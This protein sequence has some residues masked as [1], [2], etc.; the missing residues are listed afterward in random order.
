MGWFRTKSDIFLNDVVVMERDQV[1]A[2]RNPS[3][4]QSP[5]QGPPPR[6]FHTLTLL[7]GGRLLLLG[8]K[9]AALY[10]HA[11]TQRDKEIEGWGGGGRE[12]DREKRERGGGGVAWRNPSLPQ[13]AEQGR[14]PREFH[15]LTL[16]P[17]GRLL[18]LG[19][20]LST[21]DVCVWECV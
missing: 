13:S 5:E 17:G 3:F 1:V 11:C 20:G 4:P 10:V 7:P 12:R 9:H 15:T 8:G 6:E 16:L 19:G 14:S 18:L 2:W 21:L